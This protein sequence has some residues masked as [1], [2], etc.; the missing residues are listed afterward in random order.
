MEGGTKEKMKKEKGITLVSLGITIVILFILTG[1]IVDIG[2]ESLGSTELRGFYMDLEIIQKKVD[3]VANTNEVF[4]NSS[5][6]TIIVKQSGIAYLDMEDTQK[7]LLQQIK[8]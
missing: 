6:N 2:I 8:V 7:T 5:G 3:E 1:I 4:I